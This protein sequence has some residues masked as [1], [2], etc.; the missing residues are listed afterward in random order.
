[1]V[2]NGNTQTRVQMKQKDEGRPVLVLSSAT[3]AYALYYEYYNSGVL[4]KCEWNPYR[5]LQCLKN[6]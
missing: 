2:A 6:I 3:T 5:Y 4:F 1:M